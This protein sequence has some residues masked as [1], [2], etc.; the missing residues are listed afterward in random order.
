[1][2]KLTGDPAPTLR[3]KIARMLMVGFRGQELKP[4]D[5]IVRDIADYGVGGTILFNRDVMLN[6]DGRNIVSP[7]QLKSLTAQL[8]SYA[9]GP[10]FTAVD[11]EGG[12]VARLKEGHGFP[13]TVSAQHLGAVNDLALTRKHADSIATTLAE[14]GL[15][16]NLAPVVDLNLNPDCP[17][18]GR[19]ERSYSADPEIV[20]AHA[21]EFI[22]AH[23]RSRVLTCLKH[24]PGHGSATGDSHAG[25]V[26]V[27][28]TWKDIELEPYRQLIAEGNCRMVM[29]AH[30][31]NRT[32]DPV[33]PAT[34]SRATLTGI[35][36]ERIG[37]DG[38]IVSD[39]MQMGAIIDNFSFATAV[40]KAILAGVD[41]I[42]IG[43][44]LAYDPDIVPK[45]IDLLTRLVEHG[46]IPAERIDES[47]S[48]IMAM[49]YSHKV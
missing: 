21:R 16:M 5:A 47:Y 33:Y 13:P 27:S 8:R 49:I 23:D 2:E 46:T 9:T 34:L 7:E 39:D 22:R 45:T 32:I 43:N 38:V 24:F 11:Q 30:I 37:Y 26:D 14:H 6:Q 19:H 40:E 3:Q 36:R 28:D 25:F 31:F 42:L 41:I 17:V 29:T 12:K 10:L 1:M 35:L 15:N 44:N 18:I 4:I 20:T 48:R